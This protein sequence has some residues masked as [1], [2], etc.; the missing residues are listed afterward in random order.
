M[1]KGIEFFIKRLIRITESAAQRYAVNTPR[2]LFRENRFNMQKRKLIRELELLIIDEVSMLRADLLDCIDY[3]LRHLRRK[4]KQP[5]GGLQI[6]FIGDVLQLPPVVREQDKQW[7]KPY[8]P[9][10]FSFM[11]RA[12]QN[13]PPVCIELQKVYRQTDPSFVQLLNR[14]RH[15]QQTK[16]DNI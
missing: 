9:G 5:F 12:L 6:L 3:T 1:L 4:P 16:T 13:N 11:A 15:N 14:F 10:F 2:T 8:Y 7:L